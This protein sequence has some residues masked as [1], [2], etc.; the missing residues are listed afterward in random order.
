MRDSTRSSG[1]R[2]SA[3][4]RRRFGGRSF[5]VRVRWGILESRPCND[6]REGS[7]ID[8]GALKP[9]I[10]TLL[11][12]RAPQVL[13]VPLRAVWRVGAVPSV[14]A[15]DRPR[16]VRL[17]RGRAPARVGPRVRGLDVDV[18]ERVV[19]GPSCT[20]VAS[21]LHC[22]CIAPRIDSRAVM[23]TWTFPEPGYLTVLYHGDMDL[24]SRTGYV[25]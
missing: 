6:S 12:V 11:E 15:C 13:C 17:A 3:G 10:R 16:F 22:R 5:R 20:E 4:V 14:D 25:R 24:R 7:R 2:D 9:P 1:Q 8:A 19:G 18:D 21:R 23:R